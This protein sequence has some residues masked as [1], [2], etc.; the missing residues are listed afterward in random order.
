MKKVLILVISILVI[1]AA[2]ITAYITI[3]HKGSNYVYQGNSIYNVDYQPQNQY[4]CLKN[5]F[6][7]TTTTQ[8]TAINNK[9]KVLWQIPTV[10][11]K[12]K[13]QISGN[14]ILVSDISGQN[15][16]IIKNGNIVFEKTLDNPI[17][18]A[19]IN[20][21]GFL[22][23]STSADGFSSK[24]TVYN[25]LGTEIYSY[26]ISDNVAIDCLVSPDNHNLAVSLYGTE[27]S[28]VVSSIAF[29]DMS[30]QAIV[31]KPSYTNIVIS[32]L[33]YNSD[34]HLFAVGD[35][36]ALYFD[37]NGKYLWTNKYNSQIL[38]DYIFHKNNGFS[39]VFKNSTGTASTK[40]Y[41]FN[42]KSKNNIDLSFSPKNI[43][44]NKTTAI[45]AGDR[46]FA[47][48]KINGK[49]SGNSSIKKDYAYIALSDNGKYLYG[50]SGDS[51]ELI[52]LK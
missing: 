40:T 26:S 16:Y 32:N 12:P 3:N 10:C 1:I 27:N 11:S 18:N 13:L 47:Y 50:V 34:G 20:E 30:K 46:T 5:D 44:T 33:F 8:T 22:A 35:T 2:G 6:I 42:N 24:V 7:I 17:F 15:I 31:E 41:N 45:L 37:K 28:Q 38:I 4:A 9:G 14:Y 52:N 23:V 49:L 25:N 21:N 48:I 19:Q 39:L 36:A 43:S 29:I 51:I